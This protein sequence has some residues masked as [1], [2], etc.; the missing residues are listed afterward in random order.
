VVI[1]T[2][3]SQYKAALPTPIAGQKNSSISRNMKVYRDLHARKKKEQR[4]ESGGEASEAKSSE[5][6]EETSL[7]ESREGTLELFR[8]WIKGR[9][10]EEVHLARTHAHREV[11]R[12]MFKIHIA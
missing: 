1:C 12:P 5:Y 2:V 7:E 10:R 4:L 11:E 3:V 8:T 6:W 9:F